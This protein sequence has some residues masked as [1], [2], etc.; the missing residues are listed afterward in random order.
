MRR[1]EKLRARLYV[2][3]WILVV[4]LTAQTIAVCF[5]HCLT[6]RLALSETL[7]L[8]IILSAKGFVCNENAAGV[9]RTS[10][11]IAFEALMFVNF[12][13]AAQM[14]IERHDK[15]VHLRELISVIQSMPQLVGDIPSNFKVN[16]F[17]ADINAKIRSVLTKAGA[18]HV[19]V[20]PRI[21]QQ[22][23]PS[24]EWRQ[25]IHDECRNKSCC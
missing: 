18:R 16:E 21:T 2:P 13:H 23:K 11:I 7:M 1:T 22:T 3:Y 19:T 15:G 4:L 25:C 20:E 6:A 14:L 17:K 5:T 8:V 24:V 10:A 12:I 9:L